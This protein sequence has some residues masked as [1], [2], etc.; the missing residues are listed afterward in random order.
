MHNKRLYF[1]LVIALLLFTTG[2]F[3]SAVDEST[4]RADVEKVIGQF[5]TYVKA[6]D[7][8][9]IAQVLDTRLVFVLNGAT[10]RWKAAAEE[11][12]DDLDIF[13]DNFEE[14]IEKAI[15]DILDEQGFLPTSPPDDWDLPEE[16]WLE[17]ASLWNGYVSL[18]EEDGDEIEIELLEKKIAALV[19]FL[20]EDYE[21]LQ[22]LILHAEGDLEDALALIIDCKPVSNG[23]DI[24]KE[25]FLTLFHWIIWVTEIDSDSFDGY[26]WG[27]SLMLSKV[28]NK[29]KATETIIPA[30]V[31][32]EIPFT[33]ELRKLG[34]SWLIDSFTFVFENRQPR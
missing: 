2:C 26:T 30:E 17:V 29:W 28:G 10:Q 16:D 11:Y 23:L 31:D 9:S 27:N 25:A 33:L 7:E 8:S 21:D 6:N 24:P 5:K 14:E 32:Y 12:Y 22:P 3:H 34:S 20:D 13:V 1:S 19:L 15:G 18:R 4:E